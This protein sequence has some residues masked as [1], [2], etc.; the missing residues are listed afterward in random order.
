MMDIKKVLFLWFTNSLIKS[1]QVTI[2]ANNERPLDL[3]TQQLAK[4]LHKP[5]IK[6]FKKEQFILDLRTTFG[7]LI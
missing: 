5:I 7:V 3:A 4:A 1:L 6:N 2:P